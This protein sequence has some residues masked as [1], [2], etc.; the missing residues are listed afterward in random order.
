MILNLWPK[1]MSYGYGGGGGGGGGG[2]GGGGGGASGGGAGGGYGGG[3]GAGGGA[4][5]AAGGGGGEMPPEGVA[6][7]AF[8]FNTDSLK[9]E[10]FDGNQWVNITTDAEHK[11]AGDDSNKIFQA[12]SNN[13]TGMGTRG[14]IAGGYVA[15]PVNVTDE[16]DFINV[17]TTG[18][19]ADFGNLGTARRGVA[20]LGSRSRGILAGGRVPGD[21]NTIEFV[22]L[23]ST[24]NASDFGDLTQ[25]SHHGTGLSDAT[26]G[27]ITAMENPG[28]PSNN[29]NRI[30]FIT[31]A[32]TGNANDFGDLYFGTRECG[33]CAS[34]TR[35]II[36]GG[37]PSH[38][39]V[40][41]YITISTTG[42]SS[43]FG[44]TTVAASRGLGSGS[45]A[46]R[47][48]LQLGYTPSQL[49]TVDFITIAT[50]GDAKDFGDLT[51]ARS[52]SAGAASP[53]RLA[54]MGGF[55]PSRV[56][57]IDFAQIMTTGN[58]T[59]FGELVGSDRGQ[60]GG[61]SNGHGGL[62]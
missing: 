4:G 46:V 15:S 7:G 52:Q 41:Q 37:T 61:C 29:S 47:G 55:S 57:T 14:I 22:T 13:T 6:A 18:N 59:S 24:G 10:Y 11:H 5:G 53:T 17:D 54:V 56:D 40:I 48:V 32:S 49:N 26:R 1:M 35:G 39:N 33:G 51:E 42:D 21:L 50:L 20:C 43:D 44:D 62:A 23:A 60:T 36:K 9:L 34:P 8:R 25:T 12:T 45:N 2:S 31:I 38:S 27:I 16:I 58:F 3:A 19:A 28:W 30:D